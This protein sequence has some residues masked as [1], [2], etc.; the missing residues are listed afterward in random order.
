MSQGGQTLLFAETAL[1]TNYAVCLRKTDGS[2]VLRLGEG[3][4]A[5]LS[6]DGKWVLALMQSAPP[7]LLVYPTGAG[8]TRQ[9]ER[10]NLEHYATAQW[11]HDGK[12]VLIS[13]NEAGKG[14]RYVQELGGTPQPVTPEGT[15]DGLLSADG[16]LIL[17]RG[18]DGNY[19]IY[20]IAGGDLRPVPGLMPAD[21]LPLWSAD[22]HSVLVYR[23]AELPCRL[24]RVDVTTSHRTPFKEFAP[25]DRAGLLSL[26]ESCVERIDSAVLCAPQEHGAQTETIGATLLVSAEYGG[27]GAPFIPDYATVNYSAPEVGWEEFGVNKQTNTVG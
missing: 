4:P 6:A 27:V 10:G 26:L 19:F 2:A 24:E 13:G 5:D 8:E 1:G 11:F 25:A 16:K 22:E 9:L 12:R 20:P 3:W 23:R 21:I 7:R 14:T 18:P 17:A 15:S